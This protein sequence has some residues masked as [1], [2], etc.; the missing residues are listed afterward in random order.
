[1]DEHNLVQQGTPFGLGSDYVRYF[2]RSKNSRHNDEPAMNT[3]IKANNGRVRSS[4]YE[5]GAPDRAANIWGRRLQF[6]TVCDRAF[7]PGAYAL[8]NS[9]FNN[10]FCGRFDVCVMDS[11][12]LNYTVPASGVSYRVLPKVD[13]EYHQFVNRLEALVALPAGNYCYL[14]SD[15]LIERPCGEIFSAID[16]GLLVS[17]ENIHSYDPYDVCLREASRRAGLPKALPAFPYVNS[18]ILGFQ[19]PRDEQFLRQLLHV[20]RKLFRWQRPMEDPFFPQLD[21]DVLNILVRQRVQE[22]LPIFSLSP[23]RVE[24][25]QGCREH[26]NR[27]FP[28]TL[29]TDFRPRD[30]VKYLIHGASLRRPWID[31][32]RGGSK[33]TLESSGI[34][35]FR[36]KL[37]G[38]LTPYERAWA[39]FACGPG[40]RIPVTE[41][42]TK[43][44]F[45]AHRNRLWRA[46]FDL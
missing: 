27:R 9:A 7:L 44:A 18:G 10:Q 21:Q 35:P 6:I 2:L 33:G 28:H 46:V 5:V 29:Q 12:S 4:A 38:T 23:K 24:I 34:L 30:M 13:P 41:W 42:E 32:T 22:G 19:L 16:D 17:T 37:L 45:T 43:H 26:R 15:V 40:Q 39:Y 14:D 1:M 11:D 36:R 3:A 25:G 20:S 31:A 8:V